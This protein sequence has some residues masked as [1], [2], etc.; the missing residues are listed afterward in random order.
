MKK[1]LFL[2]TFCFAVVSLLAQTN[3]LTISGTVTDSISGNPVPGYPVHIDIDSASGGFIYHHIVPTMPNGYYADTVFF[4]AGYIPAGIL[5]ISAWDCRQH[6]HEGN[7]A[8]GPGN[9]NF[10]MNFHICAGPPPPPCHADFYPTLPPPPPQ[11]LTVHF[12]NTSIGANG[13]W[14]WLFGDGTT[15]TLFSPV[16]PYNA[17]GLYHVTLHMGDSANGGCFDS[18]TH[19]IQVWDSTDFHQVFGQVFEGNYLLH[20]GVVMIFSD[21]ILPGIMPYFAIS[22]LDSMGMYR[23]PFVPNGEFVIWALPF[24]SVGSY[25]PTFYEHALFW[26]QANKIQLGQPN[27][28]YN[29]HLL[30]VTDMPNGQGGINGHVNIQGLKSSGVDQIVMLLTNEQG[31]AIG[32]RRVDA[33]GTFNFSRMAYGTYFLKPELPNTPSDLVKVELS[34]ANPVSNVTLTFTG[35]EILG[36][37][38]ISTVES[39]EAYPVPVKDILNLNIRLV[40]AVNAT[41]EIY[42]FTGQIVTNKNLS[43]TRGENVVKLDLSSLNSGLYTLRI[44]SPAGIRIVQKV[45]KE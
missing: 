38:E 39:F 27:D 3:A 6:L 34:A 11:P 30:H 8:F 12:A 31:Q 14:L 41:A 1:L 32:F 21:T 44:S 43:L 15:S 45:V 13:P 20:M 17:P 35:K 16:H 36:I 33:S 19:D 22:P 23:F 9:L 37:N 2:L 40:S 42:S 28:P 25:L 5:W 26:E 10:T 24:D 7:F 29:I 4:N 18:R